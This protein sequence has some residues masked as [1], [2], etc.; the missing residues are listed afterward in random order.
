MTLF[1]RAR[2]IAEFHLTQSNWDNRAYTPPADQVARMQKQIFAKWLV[3]GA[4][5]GKRD[6]KLIIHKK[7]FTRTLP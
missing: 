6:G 3:K 7:H 4:T 2:E 1:E 5:I